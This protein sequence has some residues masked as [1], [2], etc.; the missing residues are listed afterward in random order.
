MQRSEKIPPNRRKIN[1]DRF[2]TDPHIKMSKDSTTVS[3]TVF[4]MLNNLSRDS[5][6]T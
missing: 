1:Q 3:I 4:N 6:N 5:E 2:N